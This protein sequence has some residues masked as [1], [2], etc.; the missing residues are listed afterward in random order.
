M[1]TFTNPPSSGN[2]PDDA[3]ESAPVV[4]V[5]ALHRQEMLP[6]LSATDIARI[7]PYGDERTWHAGEFVV[8]TGERAEGMILVTEGHIRV[9]QRDGVGASA[10]VVE[11]GPGNFLAEIGHLSGMPVLVDGLAVD[12]VRAIVVRPQC[13]RALMVAHAELGE[14]IMRAMM[15][16]RTALI[17]RGRGPTLIGH[18]TGAAMHALQALLRRYRYPYSIVDIDAGDDAQSVFRKFD[19]VPDDLPLFVCPN[20]TVL[21]RPDTTQVLSC[22]GL[23]PQIDGTRVY[24]VAI[25]GA[26]PAGLAASV[27]AAS[28]GLRVIVLDALS[29]GGQAGAS[30]RIENYLGFPAG[31][32]GDA[33]TT[34]AYAQAQKFGAH[35]AN[36]I[37][38]VELACGAVHRLRT[39]GGDTIQARAVIIASGAAYRRPPIPRRAEF[40][41]R[42]VYYWASP[43]EA[44]LCAKQE[45]ILVGG[46]NSAGQAAVFLG[47]HAAHVHIAIRGA[48]LEQSMSRYL[49]DRIAAQPNITVHGRTELTELI[50]ETGLTAAVLRH[51]DTGAQETLYVQHVFLFTGAKPNTSWLGS[52]RVGVDDKGFVL[53]GADAGLP[54]HSLQTCIPGVFA[55]GDVRSGSTKRVA[56]AVGEG[57]A[58]VAEIHRYLSATQMAA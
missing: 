16:R 34:N 47:S 8:R 17:Q 19:A 35:L 23:L 57:A 50:G 45:V 55:I 54:A 41:G 3:Q 21:R 44:R 46:G 1:D 36:P 52:C 28:E 4:P 39:K 26:G 24:D 25:V 6:Q 43:L 20:G 7:A 56:T 29:P 49:I 13:L 27:Y 48:D 14:T 32:S 38:V 51:R 40:E 9:I 58:V 10:T 30:A 42:G 2:A 12:D 18:G 53:T 5:M 31:I 33:L 37:E 22:L 15:L 11:H